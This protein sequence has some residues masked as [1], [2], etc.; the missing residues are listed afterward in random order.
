MANEN[1]KEIIE[2]ILGQW[3]EV[4]ASRPTSYSNEELDKL[5][6]VYVKQVTEMKRIL[7]YEGYVT[8]DEV[9]HYRL[10][11]KGLK[12]KYN[13]RIPKVKDAGADADKIVSS[14]LNWNRF[15]QL[16]RYYKECAKAEERAQYYLNPRK[17]GVDYY[18]PK[19]MDYGWLKRLGEPN[20]H[21]VLGFDPSSELPMLNAF[22]NSNPFAEPIMLGFPLVAYFNQEDMVNYYVPIATVPVNY[23]PKPTLPEALLS[24]HIEV[25]F[26]FRNARLNH[27]WFENF[28]DP[29]YRSEIMRMIDKEH[30]DDEFAGC[31]DMGAL[32]KVIHQYSKLREFDFDPDGLDQTVPSYT[33]SR[34][35]RKLCNTVAFFRAKDSNYT[36]SMMRELDYIL[37]A[38]PAELDKTSLAY[39]FREPVLPEPQEERLVPI[40]LTQSTMD[41]LSAVDSA[42]N[43]T[44]TQ[45]QGPPGTGKSQ[46]AVNI[47][48]NYL[49][50]GRNILFTSKNHAAVNAIKDKGLY[51]L[52]KQ[53]PMIQFCINEGTRTSWFANEYK[54][55]HDQLGLRVNE[56]NAI[57]SSL[58]DMNL[59]VLA[60]CDK[61]IE[62]DNK[63]AAEFQRAQAEFNK[64]E[65]ALKLVMSYTDNQ[66]MDIE[67]LTEQ[68]KILERY[69][70]H[71]IKGLFYKLVIGRRKYR[72]SL[73]VLSGQYGNLGM[74]ASR[75]YEKFMEKYKQ[76]LDVDNKYR[77]AKKDIGIAYDVY[78]NREV[79]P[80]LDKHYIEALNVIEDNAKSAAVEKWYEHSV[81]SEKFMDVLDKTRSI[82]KLRPLT[83]HRD[84]KSLNEKIRTR[85]IIRKQHQTEPAW[86]STLLSLHLA[87][88]MLPGIFDAVIIDEA[89]QCD[90]VSA[91]PAMFRAKRTIVVGDKEQLRPVISLGALKHEIIW[92]HHFSFDDDFLRLNYLNATAYN[93]CDRKSA[94]QLMLR[95][96]FRCADD[97]A[98][99]FNMRFY[100]S[101]LRMRAREHAGNIPPCFPQDQ[102][103]IWVDVPGT[104]DDEIEVACEYF[105]KIV[106]SGYKG[107]VGLISPLN[108]YA[109]RASE[110]LYNDGFDRDEYPVSTVYSFQGGEM[111]TIIYMVNLTKG[112]TKGERWYIEAPE[113]RNVHNVAVSRAKSCLVVIG[114]RE[115]CRASISEDLRLLSK[116]PLKRSD[117]VR[118]DSIWEER[119]FHALADRGIDTRTQYYF[120]GYFFDMAYIE[121]GVV[122]I[123]IEVDGKAY[124]MNSNGELLERDRRR[125]FIAERDG[126]VVRRF[127]V[128]EL[129]KDMNAC[130]DEIERTINHFRNRNKREKS[131]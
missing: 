129:M 101:Q 59:D 99:F 74:F 65:M 11:E 23:I 66:D 16:V 114:N 14:P 55:I 40:P 78:Q 56:S 128:H 63:A 20:P 117:E 13:G 93:L 31:F 18:I 70:L 53:I 26:D 4:A 110:K 37:E 121:E 46:V 12:L 125:N 6:S 33:T 103:V 92:K 83:I 126:W 105:H 122:K 7:R 120:Q 42:L 52:D 5:L 118:F 36:K 106:D 112:I 8:V 41:Q 48:A 27:A 60:E 97:I 91:I 19:A 67:T 82:F 89:Y 100:D 79:M 94:Q 107:S 130:V 35:R 44:I 131:K 21:H 98:T 71:G 75:N 57:A 104:I 77:K 73:E 95:D 45:I 127:W 102:S 84:S 116:M 43:S 54:D 72:K 113:N 88:P 49:Y 123:D 9:G 85:N 124:H 108:K 50:Y 17:N 2:N 109:G 64:A 47:I 115:A 86:T 68:A 30:L 10:T 39:V 90:P 1:V 62:A 119:F 58:V 61:L 29:E 38:S 22:V 25:E 80:D 51:L 111:D 15:K 87:A 76:I 69:N 28:I 96:H 24:N 32:L 3:V 34:S 81:E